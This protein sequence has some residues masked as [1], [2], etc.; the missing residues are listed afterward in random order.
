MIEKKDEMDKSTI[1]VENIIDRTS[2]Q[3]ISKDM[4]EHNIINQQTLLDMYRIPHPIRAEYTFFLSA[5]STFTKIN[6]ILG[7][8]TNFKKLKNLK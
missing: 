4:E 3:K 6:Y 1:I 2:R 7:H 5:H 8:K